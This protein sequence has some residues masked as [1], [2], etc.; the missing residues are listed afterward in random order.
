VVNLNAADQ[1][2]GIQTYPNP[3]INIVSIQFDEKQSGD[4]ILELVNIT[5]Q[6]IQQKTTTLSGHSFI[7]FSLNSHPP[8]G[9][10]FL[11]ARDISH[12]K[13]YVTKVLVE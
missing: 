11:R 7:S 5:G 3:V 13:Q 10:Y 9:L 1:R 6:I 2:P 12:N 4:F 8:K